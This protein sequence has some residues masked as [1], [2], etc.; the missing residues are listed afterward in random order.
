MFTPS[1]HHSADD[2]PYALYAPPPFNVWLEKFESLA[3]Y[4]FLHKHVRVPTVSCSRCDESSRRRSQMNVE[5][6][7]KDNDVRLRIAW[8]SGDISRYVPP[9]TT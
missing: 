6:R 9:P 1:C 3:H 4:H 7:T 5:L 8:H 2:A